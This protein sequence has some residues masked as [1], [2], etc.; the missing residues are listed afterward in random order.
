MRASVVVKK[1]CI[2]LYLI[3][4]RTDIE[5]FESTNIK[6]LNGSDER[7]IYTGNLISILIYI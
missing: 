3:L 5:L 1:I 6:H 4:N 2:Y 7:E